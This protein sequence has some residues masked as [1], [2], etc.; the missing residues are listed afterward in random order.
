MQWKKQAVNMY[1]MVFLLIKVK[2]SYITVYAYLCLFMSIGKMWEDYL[3]YF[4]GTGVKMAE[5]D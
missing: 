1:T 4:M 3:G 2:K 5:R